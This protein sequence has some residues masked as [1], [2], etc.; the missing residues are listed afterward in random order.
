MHPPRSNSAYQA[1]QFGD[2]NGGNAQAPQDQAATRPASADQVAAN[3]IE[4]REEQPVWQKAFV[5]GPNVRFTRTP[6]RVAAK[7]ETV[8]PMTAPAVAPA[9]PQVSRGQVAQ[10][11]AAAA[12]TRVPQAP[13][14]T[15]HAPRVN[16]RADQRPASPYGL[17]RT[18]AP[19][20]PVAASARAPIPAR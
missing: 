8:E 14:P 3:Q 20:Q 12:T 4:G 6:D 9:A 10:P 7:P 5:L 1:N 11:Q 19:Q 18:G 15:A 17:P 16:P 13:V 2:Q